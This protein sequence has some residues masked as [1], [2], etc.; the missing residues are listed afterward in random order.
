VVWLVTALSIGHPYYRTVGAQY[1]AKLGLPT[2]LMPL[3]C[4]GELVLGGLVLALRPRTWLTVL[5]GSLVLGFTAVL[6]MQEPLLLA[7][8]FGVLSKN[9]QFL[10]V[11]AVIDRV[12]RDGDW[13]EQTRLWLRVAMAA[14]WMTEG[15]FPKLLFQQEI[16]L[17]MVPRIGIHDLSPRL[18]VGALGVCQLASGIAALLLRG[19][20]L[21]LLLLGQ[22][23][24]LVCLP[25]AVGM[26]EPTLYVHP[27]GPFLKN[28]PILVGTWIVRRW[29]TGS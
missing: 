23:L 1:L 16:E 7:S 3:T 12:E 24:A 11:L 18:L 2:L 15:L 10:V 20:L 17:S 26:L 9:L 4:A 5:Q 19:G 8:P 27:F 22:A 29:C 14:V 21:R 13:T 25:L 6:A 28:I